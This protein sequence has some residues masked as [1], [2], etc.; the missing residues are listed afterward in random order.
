MRDPAA[1]AAR[2]RH[3]GEILLGQATP[4]A[5]ANYAIGVP[6]A[7]PTGGWAAATSGVSVLAFTKTSFVARLTDAGLRTLA[8]VAAALGRYEGFPAH[9]QA[10]TARGGGED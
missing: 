10:I 5:A 3:A 6:H 8:P 4:F 7:L 9:V 2:I 1:V